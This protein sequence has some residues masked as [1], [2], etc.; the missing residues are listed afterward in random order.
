M[1]AA[2]LLVSAASAAEAGFLPLV[3][4]LPWRELLMVA[5]PILGTLLLRRR[6][7]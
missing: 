3:R 7:R 1:I 2:D 4:R 5:S 6:R